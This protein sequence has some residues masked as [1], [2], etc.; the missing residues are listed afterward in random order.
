MLHTE[1][2][3]HRYL[4]HEKLVIGQQVQFFSL[5]EITKKNKLRSSDIPINLKNITKQ[6]N[7]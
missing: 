4:G 5:N 3:Y 2:N 1:E 6:G 7:T